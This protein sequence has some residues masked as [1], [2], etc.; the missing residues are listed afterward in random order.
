MSYTKA[1]AIVQY[2][3]NLLI[4]NPEAGAIAQ[5]M[6][7]TEREFIITTVETIVKEIVVVVVAI[8]I[9]PGNTT[10]KDI[11]AEGIVSVNAII[12]RFNIIIRIIKVILLGIFIK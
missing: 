9:E 6:L 12:I 11:V 1:N 4:L 2:I 10:A 5:V 3:L 8:R 7:I